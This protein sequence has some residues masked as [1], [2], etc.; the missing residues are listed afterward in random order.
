[1]SEETEKPAGT[2]KS[3]PRL[4]L[5]VS[6]HIRSRTD[7]QVVMYW[8]V[9]AL[10]PSMIWA[11]YVF[12]LRALWLTL[13]SIAAAVAAEAVCQKLRGRPI[14]VHDGSAIIT[15]ILLAYNVPPGVPF[16][17]VAVGAASGIVVGKQL[18]GGLGYNPFNPALLG[19]A[20]LMASW[21]VH[22]TTDWLAPKLG[23]LSGI[24]AVTT[25]T[26]LNL[27][28]EASRVF[29]DPTALPQQI[30][31][32]KLSVSQLY[33]SQGLINL[34]WGNVG[35]CIGEVS[36]AL[37]L[38]GAVLLFVKKIIDWRI[39]LTYIGT[40]AI[41]GWIF[42]GAKGF[43][44]GNVLFQVMSGGLILG[45]FYMATDMVTSPITQKGR[46]VFGV[47]CG[48]ITVIIRAFGG[49]PEGVSYSILLMNAFTPLIDHWT[50]PRKF[51]FVKQR[52]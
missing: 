33:S 50:P 51:G 47:L 27:F 9:V 12:G 8:V 11:V 20:F 28:K 37:L 40:V 1:M 38:L 26:P 48:V 36:V 10:V 45:A 13:T 21:P 34:F 17:L 24:D 52:V 22:M 5:S 23:T 32:A 31:Q 18:F 19:R 43:F 44:T 14:T 6:P 4:L 30:A 16:W 2:L 25:A 35:G 15:G 46:L 39:P 7:I 3:P 49:Y 42:G 29:V 41:L